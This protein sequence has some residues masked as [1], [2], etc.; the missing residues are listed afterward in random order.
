MRAD[1][2]SADL[3]RLVESLLGALPDFRAERARLG[4][5][6]IEMR[7]SLLQP[8]DN[9]GNRLDALL[10]QVAVHVVPKPDLDT[11][12]PEPGNSYVNFAVVDLLKL[13]GKG[14]HNPMMPASALSVRLVYR[15]WITRRSA[16]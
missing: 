3:R 7:N 13:G 15:V 4:R 9:L 14:I 12:V 1:Y 2:L 5:S 10:R 6:R 11:A 16:I 8:G